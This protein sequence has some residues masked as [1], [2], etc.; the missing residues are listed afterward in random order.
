[1]SFYEDSTIA[2]LPVIIQMAQGS[3]NQKNILDLFI[4]DSL[5][6]DLVQVL[7]AYQAVNA[8]AG[9]VNYGLNTFHTRI[10]ELIDALQGIEDNKQTTVTCQ[11]PDD[12]VDLVVSI[13]GSVV[14]AP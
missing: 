12:S 3:Y 6:A 9:R 5:D 7:S 13:G 14:E 8:T 10:V 11:T 2:D 4:N 1:M